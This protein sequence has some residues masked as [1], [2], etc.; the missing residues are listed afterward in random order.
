MPCGTMAQTCRDHVMCL[1]FPYRQEVRKMYSNKYVQVG[2][3][4][5][6]LICMTSLSLTYKIPYSF[7]FLL[8]VKTFLLLLKN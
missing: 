7:P 3:N 2:L 4:V 5:R 6:W 8:Q 1:V